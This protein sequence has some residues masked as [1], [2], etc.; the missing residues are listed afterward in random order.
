[1]RPAEGDR[2][3]RFLVPAAGGRLDR[4]LTVML[5]GESRSR[6]QKLIREGAVLVNG[7][8][9]TKTGFALRGGESLSIRIPAPAPAS[10]TPEPIPLDILFENDVLLVVNKPPGIVVHPSAGHSHGTLVHAVLAHAPDLSGIGDERRPGVVHR[11]DKDTSGL[12]LFAKNAAA[13][14][15]LQREFHDRRVEKVYLALVDGV[16]PTPTGRI[17][18]PIGRDPRH[19]QRMAVVPQ[20]RGRDAQTYYR[21][22]ERFDEYS[23]LELHPRTGR[24]HQIRVHLAFLGCPVTGDRVYGRRKAGLPVSRQMLHAQSLRITLPGESEPR[25]FK[26]PLPADFDDALAALR[27]DKR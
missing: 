17:E 20:S 2:L 11:L 3:E 1:M 15:A 23:L 6:L 10:L 5:P 24:T 21:T 4:I 14:R 27:G 22:L 13:Q 26:A 25:L 16:P 8:P 18:A 19:R 12:I 7:S 9:V